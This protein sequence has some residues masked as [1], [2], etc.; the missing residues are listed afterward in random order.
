MPRTSSWAGVELEAGELQ[1]ERWPVT[2]TADV[3]FRILLI[4]NFGAAALSRPTLVDRDNFDSVLDRA[5]VRLGPLRV[6]E[7]DD[8]H[9]DRLFASLDIFQTLR[10]LRG[11][12]LDRGSFQAAAAEMRSW[13]PPRPAPA[14]PPRLTPSELVASMLDEVSPAD[15][16]PER[17]IDDFDLLVRNIVAPHVEPKPDPR[18]AEM[19]AQLDET[20]AAQM[21]AI[22]HHPEFQAVES[23]WR[24]LFFL[25]RRME[26]EAGLK[27]YI[28]DAAEGGLDA[29]RRVL[30]SQ[31]I[32]AEPWALVAAALVFGANEQ[33]LER[34]AELAASARAAGAPVLAQASARLLGCRSLAAAPDPRAWTPDPALDAAWRK[35]RAAAEAPW[36]G[37]ALPRFL[38]R[39]PYGPQTSAVESFEFEEMP[40]E[41]AHQDYL[42]G[43]PVF[44]CVSLVAESYA[45]DGWGLRPGS[46]LDVDGLPAHVYRSGGESHLKPCAET[47]LTEAAAEAVLER[48]IMPLVTMKGTDRAR[49]L[50]FQSIADPPSALR[51]R[52]A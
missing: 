15:A 38:L 26:T 23:A 10:D 42:W 31:P 1:P 52:W 21:R 39:L 50:R 35:L 41:P 5:G 3:S 19:V 12:L 40:G 22:L 36:I 27:L 6:R 14:R 37:L 29:A 4:G 2:E 18:Q 17:A 43:N 16:P 8:F 24:G 44:A 7:L 11:K 49:L 46:Y 45:E 47:L 33:E 48:G 25:T 20:V 13:T 9:P 30:V 32:G 34:L 28:M 51:G